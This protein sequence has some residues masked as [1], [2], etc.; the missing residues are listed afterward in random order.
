MY[1][2]TNKYADFRKLWEEWESEKN[3][4]RRE[5]EKLRGDIEMLDS[6]IDSLRLLIENL[7]SKESELVSTGTVTA[8]GPALVNLDDDI[9]F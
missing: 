9:P 7:E 1:E 2:L 5:I 3:Q 8:I 6:C 4:K